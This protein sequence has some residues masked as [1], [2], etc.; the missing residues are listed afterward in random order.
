MPT[1]TRKDLERDIAGVVRSPVV[2]LPPAFAK[3]WQST[4]RT[5]RKHLTTLAGGDKS[6]FDAAV[7]ARNK[8]SKLTNSG[9]I[10]AQVG[11][12]LH[13]M[14]EGRGPGALPKISEAEEAGRAARLALYEVEARTLREREQEARL[15]Q[16][17]GLLGE[18]A[19][20]RARR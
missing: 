20:M 2:D 8:L 16:G 9:E 3:L 10:T 13:D 7:K 18:L 6:A 5:Y 1:S 15:A 11:E 14:I 17:R 19:V 12:K 4:V